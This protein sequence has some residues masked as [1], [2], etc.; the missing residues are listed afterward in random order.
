[1]QVEMLRVALVEYYPLKH[2]MPEYC[3]SPQFSISTIHLAVGSILT[4]EIVKKM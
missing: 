4:R 3:D 2:L 1:M